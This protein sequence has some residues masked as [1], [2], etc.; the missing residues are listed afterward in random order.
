MVVLK[1]KALL[2]ITLAV[3]MAV[4]LLV[5]PGAQRLTKIQSSLAMAP[6]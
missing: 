2:S 3:L 5:A 1:N 6:R 4:G